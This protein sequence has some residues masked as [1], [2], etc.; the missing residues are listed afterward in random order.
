MAVLVGGVGGV[1]DVGVFGGG[2]YFVV[3]GVG[4]VLFLMVWS[5]W[6]LLLDGGG[7]FTVVGVIIGAGV[8]VCAVVLRFDGVGGGLVG[9]LSKAAKAFEPR[10]VGT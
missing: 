9:Q 1:G 5:W 10:W 3:V 7:C 6:W 8:V 2:F 4:P